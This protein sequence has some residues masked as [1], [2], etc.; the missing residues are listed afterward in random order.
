MDIIWENI[1]AIMQNLN[2]PEQMIESAVSSKGLKVE[3]PK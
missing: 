1:C 2:G 3:I